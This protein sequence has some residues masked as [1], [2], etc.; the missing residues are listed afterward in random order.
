VGKN[1]NKSISSID[2]FWSLFLL[3]LSR[4]VQLFWPNSARQVPDRPDT[5]VY[6]R[7][8]IKN[9]E[10][11]IET[12][13]EVSQ[14]KNVFLIPQIH[15]SRLYYNKVKQAE[16]Y[17]AWMPPTWHITS[18]DEAAKKLE[19]IDFPFVSKSHEGRRSINVRLVKNRE[20]AL[21]EIEASFFGEGLPMEF[22]KRQKGYVFWQEFLP[23]N[24]YDWR[25][26]VIAKKY[27]YAIRR[28]NRK[29]IPLASGSGFLEYH[30]DLNA[31]LEKLLS[32]AVKFA[33]E[34]NCLLCA[35]DVLRDRKG[36]MVI[37]EAEC[38]WGRG[39][40]DYK[41]RIF[42]FKDG[43]WIPTVYTL[44]RQYD[45]IAKAIIDGEFESAALHS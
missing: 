13:E 43:K 22:G 23:D 31:E 26:T 4:V 17:P 14:K 40:V 8:S 3:I 33:R 2:S 6:Y 5:V 42:E 16:A 36:R 39:G 21:K 25:V 12:I 35:V 15:E 20:E 7:N 30:A 32:Y 41:G 11:V 37:C 10:E 18:A 44:D 27:A 19:E 28:Q 9:M 1:V 24:P 38:T 34:N 45:L 29:D